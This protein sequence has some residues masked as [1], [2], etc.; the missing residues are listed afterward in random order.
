MAPPPEE[1][2]RGSSDIS[3]GEEED[4]G[5]PSTDPDDQS[6][7]MTLDSMGLSPVGQ[8]GVTD[9]SPASARR[10]RSKLLSPPPEEGSSEVPSETGESILDGSPKSRSP[11]SGSV[12]IGSSTIERL[13]G[14]A[15]AEEEE[16][17]DTDID[18]LTKGIRASLDAAVESSDG[19]GDGRLSAVV[20]HMRDALPDAVADE[21]VTTV[22]EV[23]DRLLAATLSA[24]LGM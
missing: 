16:D 11:K 5:S 9:K 17:D 13:I 2:G 19:D 8:T 15:E 14:E 20:Y 23:A 24:A 22:A 10:R 12:Q 3:H 6:G 7:D 21:S 18:S 1:L 4:L